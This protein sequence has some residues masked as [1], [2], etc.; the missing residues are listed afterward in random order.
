MFLTEE[1][2][3]AYIKGSRDPLGMVPIWFRLGHQIIPN[4]TSQTTSVRN[5]TTLLLG[6]YLANQIVEE[7]S[8]REEE[9][10]E[11]FLR[12]EQ[13]CAYV[14]HLA[15]DV[16][17]L[18]GIEKVRKR[19]Q[20]RNS[21]IPIGA[22][23]E[24][25]ILSDQRR[26]GIWGMYTVSGRV[27]GLLEQEGLA[28]TKSAQDFVELNYMEKLNPWYQSIK[29]AITANGTLDCKQPNPGVVY[30]ALESVLA[31]DYTAE[32]LRFYGEVLRDGKQGQPDPL[33]YQDELGRI[34]QERDLDSDTS[35]TQEDFILLRD[36]AK[37]PELKRRLDLIIRAEAV[38][39]LAQV[40]FNYLLAANGES[41]GSVVRQLINRWGTGLSYIDVTT[42]RDILFEIDQIDETKSTS[43][44]F[45][46]TQR[47]LRNGSYE[48]FIR[49]L[50]SWNQFISKRRGSAPWLQLDSQDKLDVRYRSFSRTLP[51]GDEV[52][53]W[54]Q[55]GY[56]LSSHKSITSELRDRE[57]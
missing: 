50:V 39:G 26:Y 27:S 42:N 14:R 49:T 20:G 30:S 47:T 3:N 7:S 41:V 52:Y 33:P 13:I 56:F 24:G 6:R 9:A 11:I 32:E 44:H 23:S 36:L 43:K 54:W 57:I 25:Q 1:D 2:P 22:G 34:L 48:D 46:R 10:I 51:E 37:A 15:H 19:T 55:H 4:L 8:V 45:D 38:L 16:N 31:D 40:A 12:M 35:V 28:L 29:Q 17:D 53:S 18:R 21:K 5:F